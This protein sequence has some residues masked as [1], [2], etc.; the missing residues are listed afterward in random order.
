MFEAFV[1]H[2]GYLA[3]LL[4]TFIEGETI[5]AVAGFLTAQGYM[6]LRLVIVIGFIGALMG[7]QFFFYLGRRHGG[8]ILENR[9]RLHRHVK[10]VHSFFD[11][12]GPL[13]II[14]FRFVYGLRMITPVV[15]GTSKISNRYFFLLNMIGSVLWSIIVAILGF[16]LG[17]AVRLFFHE[18][19]HYEFLI[20]G[21][22]LGLLLCLH[23]TKLTCDY[24]Y[25]KING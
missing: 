9:P 11:W 18:A 19:R 7:D 17:N 20:A 22:L 6:D 10:K 8:R 13:W 12:G 4:G 2:Y 16:L 24:L 1:T 5:L 23:L 25:I 3:V 14:G 15:L 21:I